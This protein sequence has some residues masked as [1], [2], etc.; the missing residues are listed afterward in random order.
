MNSFLIETSSNGLSL[1]ESNDD[2]ST[3]D[4]RI[5]YS[6]DAMAFFS[7]LASHLGY[8]IMIDNVEPKF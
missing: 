7:D 6:D 3:K 8:S 4:S 2:Y 1:V 5:Y